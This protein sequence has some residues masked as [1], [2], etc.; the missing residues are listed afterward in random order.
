VGGVEPTKANVVDGSYKL[1]RELYMYTDGAPR[2]LV[3]NFIDF[4]LSEEGQKLAEKSGY[5]AVK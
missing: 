2:G 4:V 3:K 1:A 5:V